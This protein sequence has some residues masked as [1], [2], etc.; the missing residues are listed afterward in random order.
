MFIRKNVIKLAIPIM[1]EQTFVMLL[2]VFN[3]MMA[4]S[5]WGRSCI[6]SWNG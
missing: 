3:T 5:Y 1:I 2:G 4:G 6:C